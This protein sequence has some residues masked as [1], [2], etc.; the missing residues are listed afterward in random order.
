M[1]STA[2]GQGTGWKNVRTGLL[3]AFGLALVATLG[4]II[5]SNTGV[6]ASH[7]AVY[8]VVDDIRGLAAGN[9]VQIA[10]MKVGSVTDMHFTRTKG[11]PGVQVELSIQSEHF[12][13]ITTDSKAVIK[14][15]G[16]LGDKIV[17]I[18]L[19]EH[20]KELADGGTL[21]VTAESGLA[22]AMATGIKTLNSVGQISERL[23]GMLQ[24]VDDGE[25][26]I[27]RLMTTSDLAEELTGM[28][29]E[30]RAISSRAANGD[31]AIWRALEDRNVANDFSR[32]VASLSEMSEQL[33]SVAQSIA[34]GEGTLGKL[35]RN[36]SL[37]DDIRGVAK[38]SDSMIVRMEEPINSFS[39]GSQLYVNLNRSIAAL[40]SL[41]NDMKRRP[42]RYVRFSVFK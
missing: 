38:R 8:F 32:S 14:Q 34:R 37:Y 23:N 25:G 33:R 5:N 13:M 9:P 30:I 7:R 22:E 21:E 29:T 36:D 12:P 18:Q 28:V 26:T 1:T 24:R 6:L 15:V 2:N 39:A 4:L 31:G 3:F 41:L 40:D 10:G 19:G 16:M 35:V 17:E 27:G 11:K 20:G 42:D